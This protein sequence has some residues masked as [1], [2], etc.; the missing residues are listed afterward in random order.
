MSDN[1]IQDNN[2][3]VPSTFFYCLAR[4]VIGAAAVVAAGYL[5]ILFYVEM[6]SLFYKLSYKPITEEVA[7]ERAV[8]MKTLLPTKMR[9]IS[10]SEKSEIELRAGTSIKVIAVCMSPLNQRV[11]E[12]LGV[13]NF[14]QP[15]TSYTPSQVYLIETDNGV[16]GVAA[17]PEMVI[18]RRMRVT[19]GEDAGDTLLVTGIKKIQ[20]K[21]KYPYEFIVEGRSTTYKWG[22]FSYPRPDSAIVV[23]N[24]PSGDEIPGALQQSVSR[25]PSFLRTPVHESEGFF[26]FPRYKVWNMYKLVPFFRSAIILFLIWIVLMVIALW[27]LS[28]RSF[29]AWWKGKTRY[30]EDASYDNIDAQSKLLWLYWRKYYP[31]AFIAGCMFTPLI[32]LWTSRHH[33][34]MLCDLR[35]LMSKRCPQCH[36]LSLKY[37]PSG[38]ESERRF[39]GHVHKGAHSETVVTGEKYDKVAKQT[40]QDTVTTRYEAESYDEYE[41]EVEMKLGCTKCNFCETHWETRHEKRNHE[42]G[43]VAGEVRKTWE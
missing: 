32:W 31:F 10:G 40:R 1:D 43:G 30:I 12:Q 6:R 34:E 3:H 23:Y 42:G 20:S 14:K 8:Q 7:L 16:R 9:V 19:E 38:K 36:H 4:L 17:L 15:P 13:H 18:G 5:S 21:D 27:R 33:R 11:D 25:V 35:E 22:M 29:N 2:P 39:I 28:S 37:G 24:S 26:L 41:Y